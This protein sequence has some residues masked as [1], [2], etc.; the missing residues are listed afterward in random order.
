MSTAE[1]FICR[2]C[3]SEGFHQHVGRDN[4]VRHNVFAFNGGSGIAI[5]VGRSRQTGYSWPGDNYAMN[6]VFVGN[7]VLQDGRPFFRQSSA[8]ALAQAVPALAGPL[9]A[10]VGF[11]DSLRLHLDGL[12]QSATVAIHGD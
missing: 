6:L 4:I 1:G 12:M 5:S 10:Y 11:V 9:K 2:N 8:D 3:S 7:V